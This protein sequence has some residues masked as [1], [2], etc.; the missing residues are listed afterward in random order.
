MAHPENPDSRTSTPTRPKRRF[1][2]GLLTGS[3]LGGLMATTA[4][5]VAHAQDGPRWLGGRCMHA[6]W[7]G[8]DRMNPE[9]IRERLEFGTDW[10]LSRIQATDA[11]KAATREVVLAAFNDVA[12]LR[13]AHHANRKAIMETLTADVV[14]RDRLEALRKAELALA[15]QA[16]SRITRALAD[17]AD[18]LTPEQRRALAERL[19]KHRGPLGFD[20]NRPAPTKRS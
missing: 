14:D 11:Q 3:I 20:D 9:A 16:S 10:A 1:L 2:A 17:V 12:A 13:E 4:G 19:R 18:V 8:H 7:G 6:G 5:F 15:E